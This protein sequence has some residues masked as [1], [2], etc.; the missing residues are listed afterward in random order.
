MPK[1]V[2]MVIQKNPKNNE[3]NIFFKNAFISGSIVK[4][5]LMENLK[6]RYQQLFKCNRIAIEYI[7]INF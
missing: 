3:S 6:L 1:V 5:G 4:S 7:E 2:F